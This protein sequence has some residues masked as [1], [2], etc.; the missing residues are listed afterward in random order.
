MLSH[1]IAK[2]CPVASS[3]LRAAARGRV[4]RLLLTGALAWAT[5]CGGDAVAPDQLEPS[6][7]ES[8]SQALG[9][10]VY[11][12]V[13]ASDDSA[14]HTP[15]SAYSFNSSGLTNRIVRTGT[16]TYRVELPGVAGFGGNAQVVAYG[17]TS[18]RCKVTSWGTSARFDGV[19]VHVACHTA[20]GAAIDSRFVA[21]YHRASSRD[22]GAYIWAGQP[23]TASYTPTGPSNWSAA[24]SGV[25]NTVTRYET[26]AYYVRLPD[27]NPLHEAGNALVTAY[28]PGSSHCWVSTV[29]PYAD[30][31]VRVM[32]ADS[33]GA[34]TDSAFSLS[35]SLASVPAPHNWGGYVQ[36]TTRSSALVLPDPER[37][38]SASEHRLAGIGAVAGQPRLKRNGTGSYTVVYPHM[39]YANK[40]SAFVTATSG[41]AARFAYC[42]IRSWGSHVDGGAAVNVACFNAAGQPSDA[43]FSQRYLFHGLLV[44]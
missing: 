27:Q 8:T 6:S 21:S 36:G 18:D 33:N 34:L 25:R 23:T 22:R 1:S 35:Y 24:G 40:T 13:W 4:G 43:M 42:K 15:P 19:E 3:S 29:V 17:S 32:C 20:G 9:S 16:G 39:P 38:Y 2:P 31:L 26:G 41:H 44:F 11:A 10:G 28:G 12:F 5:A 37:S 30:V 7:L 14:D